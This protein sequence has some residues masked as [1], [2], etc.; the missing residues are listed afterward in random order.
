MLVAPLGFSNGWARFAPKC[1]ERG[2]GFCHG[3]KVLRSPAIVGFRPA[4]AAFLPEL[5][6]PLP[7]NFSRPCRCG[8]DIEQQLHCALHMD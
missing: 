6:G 7:P 4:A 2:G 8:T 3:A 5:E 1:A